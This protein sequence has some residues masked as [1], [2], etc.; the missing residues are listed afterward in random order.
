MN[1]SEQR[2]VGQTEVRVDQIIQQK[3]WIII[4]LQDT[5]LQ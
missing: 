2:G 1:N 3:Q 5:I 4:V